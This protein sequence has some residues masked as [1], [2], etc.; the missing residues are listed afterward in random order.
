MNAVDGQDINRTLE[1]R[2]T[3]AIVRLL[4]TGLLLIFLGLFILVLAD[5]APIWTIVGA[6]FCLIVGSGL[7]GLALWRRIDHGKPLFALS[8]DGI[9]YRIPGVKAFNIP[10]TEVRA[11]DSIDV[12][13][14][15]WSFWDFYYGFLPIPNRKVVNHFNVTVVLVSRQF[16]DARMFAPWFF[17]RGLGWRANFIPKDS[18]VQVALHHDLVWVTARSLRD[19]VEARWIAFRDRP[20]RT[21]VPSV[22]AGQQNATAAS[23]PGTA[24]AAP[25]P[26]VI[27]MGENPKAVSRWHVIAS[28][29]LVVGIAI[30][31]ANLAG[32][33]DLPG[34]NE[35]REARTKVRTEQKAWADTIKRNREDSKKLEAEQKELRRQLDED[36]R[37]MFSR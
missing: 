32:L 27:A 36:M 31:L 5:P 8:P 13:A 15:Y 26:V 6:A 1:Y 12:Q 17:L 7:V 18:L 11:V 29:V 9:R 21:S 22:A 19:A 2:T 30:M 25:A 24:R 14:T 16:Y 20:G 23:K 33:W 4:P 10:W 28:T 3:A 37:R 35:V 34:Q